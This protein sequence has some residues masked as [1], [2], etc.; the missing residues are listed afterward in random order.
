M[1]VKI[2]E[3]SKT[4]A[5]MIVFPEL[6]LSGYECDEGVRQNQKPCAMHVALAESI[7][8]PSTEAIGKLAKE[9]G[10]FIVFGLP[11]IDAQ[12]KEIIYN[13]VAVLGP[14]GLIG[15]YRKLYLPGLPTFTETICFKSGSELPVFD[16]PYGLIGMQICADLALVPEFCRIQAL[17]GAQIVISPSAIPAGAG[18]VS[19]IPELAARR[20]ADNQVYTVI[21]NHTGKEKSVSFAGH[22][23]IA[24][25][26]PDK[27]IN[28]FA[29]AGDEE[30]IIYA[31]INLQSLKYIQG[32]RNPMKKINWKFIASEYAQLAGTQ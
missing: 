19:S 24:G 28:I 15:K 7:P 10:V 12:D 32:K 26:L 22:S 20:G 8:G 1:K 6:A 11:E 29:N 13:S 5:D 31:T 23:T 21:S 3:A 16:T 25:P 4:G 27:S 14:E 2:L 30:E 9:L 17:K 18:R